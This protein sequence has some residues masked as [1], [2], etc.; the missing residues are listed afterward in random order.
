MPEKKYDL[1][2]PIEA[3]YDLTIA[4]I[5]LILQQHLFLRAIVG[6]LGTI[7]FLIGGFFAPLYSVPVLSWLYGYQ[8][9]IPALGA[10]SYLIYVWYLSDRE[11]A[12]SSGI[13]GYVYMDLTLKTIIGVYGILLVTVGSLLFIFQNL[14]G[15]DWSKAAITPVFS[16]G[17]SAVGMWL[18]ISR[19]KSV[20]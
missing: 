6:T 1:P 9:A 17:L 10:G 18:L 16:G 11:N 3:I 7:L 4:P 14:P 5:V 12:Q 8:L 15:L 20:K 19:K 2:K 13:N